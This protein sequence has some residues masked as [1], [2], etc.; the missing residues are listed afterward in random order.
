MRVRIKRIDNS[1]PL[2]MYQT[3]GAVG[4][5]LV[6]RET[7]VIAAGSVARVSVNVIVEVP[8]GY[9]LLIKD[10]SSTAMKK[11]LIITAG[12]VDQDFCG[13]EDEIKCQFFNFTSESVTVERG[14]RIAQ[15]IFVKVGKVEWVEVAEIKRKSRGGFGS[16]G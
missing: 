16:T 6:V 1:L 2:P 5:D 10:R 15:G 7:V 9:M 14:E 11:G 13:E 4:C 3:K 8:E 12:V